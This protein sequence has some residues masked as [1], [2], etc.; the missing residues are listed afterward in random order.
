MGTW[1]P[2]DLSGA[3]VA[4]IGRLDCMPRARIAQE[5]ARR[6]GG[7]T[8]RRSA[9]RWLIVGYGAHHRLADGSLLRV[10]RTARARG[11]GC[12]SEQGFLRA[13]GMSPPPRMSS[14]GIDEIARHAR[15]DHETILLLT[16]FDVLEDQDGR[17]EFRDLVA[18]REV[19]RLIKE[20]TPLPRIIAAVI[21]LQRRLGDGRVL[22][23]TR[24]VRLSDGELARQV[25]EY[26]AEADGQLRLALDDGGNPS[27]DRLFDA[28]AIAEE[29]RLWREAEAVYRHILRISP[30]RAIAWF[31]LANVLH[32]MG[33][34]GEGQTCLRRAVALD[35]GLVEAWY[36]LAHSLEATGERDAARLCL[37]RAIAG[38]AAYADALYS[39][40][41]SWL[42]AG[43]PEKA[44]PLY[45][46]YLSLDKASAWAER[47]RRALQL[48]RL[49]LQA[50][51]HPET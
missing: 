7:M 17:Y 12:L 35:P 4:V 41:R 1:V 33:R 21:A 43:H 37:E 31:N 8:E 51:P 11:L 16:V 20:G 34:P 40:A 39:L 30:R 26:L 46:R 9:A 6:G 15:L 2:V 13:L 44:A 47:A 48:C 23:Q 14:L 49:M 18:A 45:E 32:A 38:D 5:M 27:L 28:A 24:L 25:G 19:E 29:R 42:R 50:A 22:A 10:L 3:T 36:N